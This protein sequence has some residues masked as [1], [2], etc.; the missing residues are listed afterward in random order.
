MGEKKAVY[1][2]YFQNGP[3]DLLKVLFY[4]KYLD[5]YKEDGDEI[6][7]AF[8]KAYFSNLGDVV[9]IELDENLTNEL[10]DVARSM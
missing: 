9:N 10:F 4:Y 6:V 3:Y 5:Y 2:L 7:N 1:Y 8:R